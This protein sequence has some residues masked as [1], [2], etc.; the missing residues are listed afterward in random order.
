MPKTKI[1]NY[2]YEPFQGDIF[3][4]VVAAILINAY[5]AIFT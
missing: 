5:Y 1:I 4:F 2:N 3:G